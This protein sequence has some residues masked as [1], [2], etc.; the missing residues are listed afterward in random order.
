MTTNPVDEKILRAEWENLFGGPELFEDNKK[1]VL[2]QYHDALAEREGRGY[3][4]VESHQHAISAVRESL[5]AE[6]STLKPK[7]SLHRFMESAEK[8]FVASGG[9]ADEFKAAWPKI[10][11]E[12]LRR[13]ALDPNVD[14]DSAAQRQAKD[15]WK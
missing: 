2:K 14:A 4:P 6:A 1:R 5:N 7:V 13:Q 15:V 9:S 3:S 11:A 12:H 8:R 10:R